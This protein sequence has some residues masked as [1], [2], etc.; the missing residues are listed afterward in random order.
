MLNN[1]LLLL[2]VIV[3][4]RGVLEFERRPGVRREKSWGARY[5]SLYDKVGRCVNSKTGLAGGT[6]A[7]K[8]AF[9]VEWLVPVL[10]QKGKYCGFSNSYLLIE[11]QSNICNNRDV[12][13]ETWFFGNYCLNLF[14]RVSIRPVE[15]DA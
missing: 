3:T 8:H 14:K 7:S 15:W 13:F 12:F 1:P 9:G 4:N 11:I 5:Q 10:T 2:F 6:W